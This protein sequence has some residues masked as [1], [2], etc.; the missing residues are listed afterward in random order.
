MHAQILVYGLAQGETE[1]YTEQLLATMCRDDSDV[2]AVK[3]AAAKDGWH[4]FRVTTWNGQAP[5]F[6]GTLNK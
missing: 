5:D 6:A 3:A 4:S 1:R 2:A